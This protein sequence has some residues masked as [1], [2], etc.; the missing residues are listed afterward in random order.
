MG[1]TNGDGECIGCVDGPFILDAEEDSD[2]AGDLRFFGV[3]EGGDALFDVGGGIFK[4]R[5][6][7]T[8]ACDDGDASG[9]TEFDGGIGVFLMEDAF[10]GGLIGLQFFEIF[11]QEGVDFEKTFGEGCIS[12]DESVGVDVFEA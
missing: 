4:E 7:E 11:V 3:T 9:V 12:E 6:S 5:H 2:H 10:E 8:G 1:V